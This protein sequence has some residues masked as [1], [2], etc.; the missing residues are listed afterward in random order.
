MKVAISK[1]TELCP[2][3]LTGF[4]RVLSFQK[5]SENGYRFSESSDFGDLSNQKHYL[6]SQHQFSLDS[7]GGAQL[8]F[9]PTIGLY[10][11]YNLTEI[12]IPN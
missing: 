5:V 7:R 4:L 1:I 8:D 12:Y 6:L 2:H 11:V 10:S 3:F 9:G